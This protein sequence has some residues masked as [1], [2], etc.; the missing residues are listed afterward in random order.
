M[1]ETQDAPIQ[2]GSDDATNQQQL[3]GILEQ[4]RSD[5]RNGHTHESPEQLLRQRVRESGVDVSDERLAQLA[6]GLS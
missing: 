2:D 1:S 5:I 6:Q 4:V 3:D